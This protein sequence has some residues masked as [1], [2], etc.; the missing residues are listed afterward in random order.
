MSYADEIIRLYGAQSAGG[1]A[2]QFCQF[3]S[4]NRIVLAEVTEREAAADP[5]M[6]AN[7]TRLEE[8]YRTLSRGHRRP[9]Q[10]L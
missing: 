2:D 3:A 9:R 7:H 5:I 4:P 6:A 1:H 10:S 8:V